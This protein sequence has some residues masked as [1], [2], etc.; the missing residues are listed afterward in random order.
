MSISVVILTLN[1]E[2]N[3]PR[4][5]ASVSWSDD[6]VVVDSGSFDN[7]VNIAERFGAAIYTRK[8]DNFAG[9]RNFA[10]SSH[11]FKYEW[12]LHL[13][14]DEVVTD[15]LRHEL[16]QVIADPK[17]RAYLLPSKMIFQGRW[18][19]YSGMYP[20]YQ[21]RLSRCKGFRFKQLGHG[22]REDIP[23]EEVGKI[24]EAYLHYSFSK[25]LGDWFERHNRYSTDEALAEIGDFEPSETGSDLGSLVSFDA[26]LRR[27]AL[28]RLSRKLP[29][30]P[31]MRF[32][33]MYVLRRGFLD[34]RAG[35]IYCKLLS[36]YE[37]MIIAKKRELI[38]TI[39][40]RHETGN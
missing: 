40:N 15:A 17:F 25:G 12:V 10:L 14:A 30:R 18:L 26:L 38:M 11:N 13:D 31:L 27:R 39:K 33:Y 16:L 3:L 5:L 2:Q 20:T 19:R 24:V 1:E 21:V 22:Q 7:T 9:Q 28:R 23:T 4:C 36:I 8:F 32:L 37:F 6:I 34:G 35:F 29:F